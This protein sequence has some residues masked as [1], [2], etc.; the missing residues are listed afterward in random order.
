MIK[1]MM[2]CAALGLA[3]MLA[4]S[5]ASAHHSYGAFDTTRE[6]Q[7]EGVVEHFDWVA[8]HSIIT[9]KTADRTY[10]GEWQAPVSLTR[11]G[12]TRDV[13]RTGDRVIVSGNPRRD[14]AETGIINVRGVTRMFDG[15]TWSGRPGQPRTTTPPPPRN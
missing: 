9:V 10:R 5:S 15:W 12:M 14:I 2:V 1:R 11:F 13:L 8:P 3:G 6:V 7:V 4:G